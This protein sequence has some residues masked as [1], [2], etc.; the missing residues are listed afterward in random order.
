[1]IHSQE[2]SRGLP[3]DRQ[4]A[5]AWEFLSGGP[6][7][8]HSGRANYTAWLRT[9]SS[10]SLRGSLMGTNSCPEVGNPWPSMTTTL[11]Q[12][13]RQLMWLG[14]GSGHTGML[15]VCKG[16]LI[17][18]ISHQGTERANSPWNIIQTAKRSGWGVRA[19]TVPNTSGC[20][21]SPCTEACGEDGFFIPPN[22]RAMD[23]MWVVVAA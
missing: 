18:G 2:I 8:S 16:C 4:R 17:P 21:G 13:A 11:P 20:R 7:S 5:G 10:I 23:L 19:V 6:V 3:T 9:S 12:P 1:M 14:P 22:T 15:R